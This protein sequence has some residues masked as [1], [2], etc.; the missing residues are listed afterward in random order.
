[1]PTVEISGWREGFRKISC[2]NLL[3]D[4]AG[5]SLREAKGY[6]DRVLDGER[7]TI[8]VGTV[9]A[10]TRLAAALTELGADARLL[11][12]VADV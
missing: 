4:V 5:L 6:T 11:D 8:T 9:D 2:T 3:R 1:M 10:A 7:V 12:L